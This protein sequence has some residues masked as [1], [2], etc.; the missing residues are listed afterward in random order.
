MAAAK[1]SGRQLMNELRAH[2]NQE[3]GEAD[4]SNRLPRLLHDYTRGAYEKEQIGIYFLQFCIPTLWAGKSFP[5][6]L[7]PAVLASCRPADSA[8]NNVDVD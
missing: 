4:K 1:V 5:R 3:I 6:I 8:D 2:K 7:R